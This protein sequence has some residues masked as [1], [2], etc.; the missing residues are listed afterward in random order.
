MGWN[1]AEICLECSKGFVYCLWKKFWS[2]NW[3]VTLQA[4]IWYHKH[5]D[6]IILK[7]SMGKNYSKKGRNKQKISKTVIYCSYLQIFDFFIHWYYWKTS[8]A[9]EKDHLHWFMIILMLHR[10]RKV[11]KLGKIKIF[12]PLSSIFWTI[13]C[14]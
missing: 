5:W 12:S 6:M 9:F 8:Q 11:N 7:Y 4:L 10:S 1:W 3:F 13:F 14:P 2:Q